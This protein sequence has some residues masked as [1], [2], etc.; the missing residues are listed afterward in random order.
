MKGV[1]LPGFDMDHCSPNKSLKLDAHFQ[2]L[3]FL[4]DN[5]WL[6]LQYFLNSQFLQI[7]VKQYPIF[8]VCQSDRIG[9][10]HLQWAHSILL[11]FRFFSLVVRPQKNKLLRDIAAH[12]M[13]KLF[14]PVNLYCTHLEYHIQLGRP[15]GVQSER[16]NYWSHFWNGKDLKLLE[17]HS[18]VFVPG[19]LCSLMM[20]SKTQESEAEQVWGCQG[21]HG[22]LWCPAPSGVSSGWQAE[23]G[24]LSGKCLSVIKLL[25]IIVCDKGCGLPASPRYNGDQNQWWPWVPTW[26]FHL[27]KV[28]C[29]LLTGLPAFCCCFLFSYEVLR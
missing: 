1:L 19:M 20:R 2:L 13:K 26:V 23:R 29:L 27:C 28:Q 14:F 3:I 24:H 17:H 16:Q 21:V 7:L 15:Q 22:P 25:Q 18:E 11:W 6:W 5:L 10:R 12:I 4:D 9:G 8:N